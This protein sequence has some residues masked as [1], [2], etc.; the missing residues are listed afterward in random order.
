MQLV[1]R[2]RSQVPEG[3]GPGHFPAQPPRHRRLVVGE[4][5]LQVA[6]PHLPDLADPALLDQRPGQGQRGH[7]AIVEPHHRL[8]ATGTRG[9]RSGDHRLRLRDRVRER[10]LDQDVL[11]GLEGGQGHLG[12]QV[13]GRADVDDV[14]VVALDDRL[15]V[16]R[17]LLPSVPVRSRL[18]VRG[19]APDQQLLA[20]AYG[21]R[22]ERAD[23]APG[24]GVRLAHERVANNRHADWAVAAGTHRA[25]PED[26]GAVS[27][28][29]K[30][31]PSPASASGD[32]ASGRQIDAALDRIS[33]SAVKL[34]MFSGPP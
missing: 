11:A 15:P 18:D 21:V 17:R 25:P 1:H 16:G 12:M 33:L 27:D 7:P 2:V 5:I 13:T 20:H 30:P 24:V 10:L 3:A 9:D 34:S 14:D 4:P 28:R 26:T 19:V 23:V 6:D 29:R 8:H 22:E 32:A 31:R